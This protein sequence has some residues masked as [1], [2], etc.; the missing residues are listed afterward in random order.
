MLRRQCAPHGHDLCGHKSR[1]KNDLVRHVP[2]HDLAERPIH[3]WIGADGRLLF[4]QDKLALKFAGLLHGNAQEPLVHGLETDPVIMAR[5]DSMSPSAAA[6]TPLGLN[7]VL[8]VMANISIYKTMQ[9]SDWTMNNNLTTRTHTY[10][11]FNTYVIRYVRTIA[12]QHFISP[13]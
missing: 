10:G 2:R 4:S 11:A 5:Y 13:T 8:K 12:D 6:G 3:P 9:L 7:N 1:R